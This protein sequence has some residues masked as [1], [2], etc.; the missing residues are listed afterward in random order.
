M[1][2]TERGARTIEEIRGRTLLLVEFRLR[3]ADLYS[4]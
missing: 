1:S 3:L 2:F 4:L